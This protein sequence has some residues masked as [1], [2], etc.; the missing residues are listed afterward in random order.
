[1]IVLRIA[2]AMIM[3]FAE[4]AI[5][6]ASPH[7]REGAQLTWTLALPFAGMLLTI[8]TG[9]LLFRRLWHHHY[10]KLAFAWAAA[11]LLP[12]ALLQG[13]AAAAAALAHAMLGDYLG[14]IALIVA[15]YVVAGGILVTGNLR[16]TPL[17]NTLLLGFGTLIASIVGTTGAAMI[18]IRPLLRANE[19]RSTNAHVV[20]FF[21]FLVCNIGGALSPLGDPPLFIGFLN[22]VDFFWTTRHLWVQTLLVTLAVLTAFAAL[23]L[24]IARRHHEHLAGTPA[25]LDLQ[26]RGLVN[27]ALIGLIIAAILASAVW[28]PGIAFEVLGTVVQLQNLARDGALILIALASLWLTPRGLRHANGFSFAPVREVAILFAAIFVCIGPVLAMLQAGG[29]GP[30]AALLALVTTPD[31]QPR[32][33]A[34]FWLTGALSGFLDNAPT[35]LVFFGLA[36]ADAA[37]LMTTL[38]PT[39]AAISMGAVYMGALS[40][41]GNAP[42]F[43]VYAIAVER[44]VRMPGFFGYMLWSTLVL[45]PIFLL[46]SLIGL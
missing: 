28:R 36:G 1:M 17:V 39:L 27:L 3:A 8:A 4:P 2:A 19:H 30:F 29:D 34:Y 11:T 25:R 7:A 9:P 44:G 16:G 23:D 18:L 20:V 12:I 13:P 14:F 33:A 31:G 41:I 15:L 45:I 40:Y 38:A 6:A 24:V 42:N 37:R 22:G 21:I 46:L 26:V 35:Y 43:M 5:A 32:V 10:D